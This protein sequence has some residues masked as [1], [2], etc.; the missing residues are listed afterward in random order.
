M[1]TAAAD[2]AAGGTM[3]PT[4]ADRAAAR[5]F[6]EAVAR[7]KPVAETF[8]RERMAQDPT[9]PCDVRVGIDSRAGIGPNAF[10]TVDNAGEPIILFNMALVMTAQNQDELAFV[11]GHE[12]GHLLGG[13]IHR[14]LYGEVPEVAMSGATCGAAGAARDPGP[15]TTRQEFEREADLI[16]A[17][18]TGRAGYDPAL[19]VRILARLEEGATAGACREGTH[20]PSAD[21]IEAVFSLLDAL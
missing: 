16:G 19:G 14:L 15:L 12:M 7:V 20:L 13:H 21:R 10:Q 6:R 9:F 4:P 8:C 1:N 3:R 18:I 11:F 2:A 5:N 17:Q